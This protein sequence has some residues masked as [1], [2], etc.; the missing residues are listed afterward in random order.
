[1]PIDLG[2]ITFGIG[3]DTTRLRSAIGDITGFSAA[4]VTAASSTAAGA[5]TVATALA[6][7]EQAAINALQKVQRF[8]DAVNRLQA[9][10]ALTRGLNQISTRGLDLLTQ[11]MT[12]GQLTALQYQREM[13]RFAVTMNNAQRIMKNFAEAQRQAEASSLIASMQKLTSAAVLVAGPLSG[14]ATRFSVL[15]GLAEHF[16]VTWALT[17]A[18]IAGGAYSFYKFATAAVDVEKQLQGVAQT[19]T[20]VYGNVT[21]ANL[22]FSYLMDLSNRTGISFGTLAKQYS[23]IEA[24]AKGTTLEGERVQKVFEAIAFAGAKLGLSTGEVE[25]TMLAIQQMMSKGTI[26]ME[27]LKGQLGDRL[28]GALQIMASALGVTTQK[29]NKMVKD[30]EVGASTLTKFADALLK[31]YNI[32]TTQKIDNITA[33]EGRLR[34]ARVAAID[35]LDKV[36][37]FSQA[38]SNLVTKLGEGLSGATGNSRQFV[39]VMLQVAVA[40]TAAF[41]APIII[42]GISSITLGIASLTRGIWLLNAASAAGAFT[43]F[44]KLLATATI[45]IAAYY[46]SEELINKVLGKTQDSFLKTTPAVE[47]YIKA[48]KELV[49]SVRGPT[50]DYI[51]QQEEMLATLEKQAAMSKTAIAPDAAKMNL[52]EGLG[53]SQEQLD[54][55]YQTLDL[56]PR[57]KAF[58]D[59]QSKI[60]ST[61]K[62]IT[63]LQDILKRQTKAEETNRADP[64]KEITDRAKSAMDKAKETIR[65]LNAKY[66]SLYMA[67]AAKELADTQEEI[68]HK[69]EAF[70]ENLERA[71]VPAGDLKKLVEDYGASLKKL[72]LG[73][74]ALK[75]QVSAFQLIGGVFSRGIDTGVQ[76]FV[77][78]LVEGKN[79]MVA[80]G[81]TVRAVAADILKTLLT[82]SVS[83]PLKNFLFG[84]N[85]QTLGGN[86]GVGGYLGNLMGLGSSS[87][88]VGAVNV[89]SYAMPTIGFAG[90]GVMGPGGVMP[91]KRYAGGGV[92]NSA[93]YA[94]FGEGGHREAYVPLPDG[95]SIPVTMDGSSGGGGV[96]LHIHNPPGYSAQ[97]QKSKGAQG[98][99]RIDVAFKQMVRDAFHDDLSSAGPMSKSMERQFGLNRAKGLA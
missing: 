92:A 99:P 46:G 47:D 25:G 20:A 28:P 45:A 1:M 12:S 30:G 66:N 14:I 16:N 7:Q 32:D 85:N 86:G 55:L 27:E 83:N 54:K 56:S 95:R 67:P 51:K 88:A 11:R 71:K 77:D 74:L 31:R 82:L 44:V 48:Q 9:P 2:Q 40:L 81:D 3:A 69:I 98:K 79:K 37:G 22:Q 94:M 57:L 17:I 97:P 19:L 38:Y 13:E 80:L 72:D 59:I 58:E 61:K 89:G 84:M 65:D 23:Q 10:E 39:Q 34:N 60:E 41:A 8:Q 29:L 78:V 75:N 90:G 18:G 26:Q 35:S 76:N 24:A 70:K 36:I 15:T 21:I 87:S 50:N 62:N 53:A 64:E 73:T 43:S 91:L 49:T 68:N 6:K 42:G 5:N 63:E 96:E 4:V 33:A 93:Q 52:A